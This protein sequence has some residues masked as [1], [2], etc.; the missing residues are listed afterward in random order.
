[1][2]LV[3]LDRDGV[4]N[5]DSDAFI[6]SPSE[7]TPIPGSLEAV[8][9]LHRAEYRVLIASNQ[10]GIGRGL[11][12]TD[13]LS[14]IHNAMLEQVHQKGGEIEAIFFCPHAPEAACHCR[15]PAPGML[16]DI[17]ERLKVSLAGVPVVGDSLRDIQS[18]QSVGA[19]PVLVRTG[20]GAR[21]ISD[22]EERRLAVALIEVPV[23][24]DL[25][26]FVD[27]LL[28]GKL[29]EDI[30]RLERRDRN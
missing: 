7:W 21:T 1:M 6:K 16:L 28:E 20:K 18:A 17:A 26:A 24:D 25:A 23:F 30:A 2:K 8:A 3:I 13:T 27:A 10:S 14:K 15:K 11:F 12:T 9:R 29:D 5:E 4:L 19:L 22:L